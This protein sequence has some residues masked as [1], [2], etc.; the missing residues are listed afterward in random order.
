[1]AELERLKSYFESVQIPKGEFRIN[2]ATVSHNLE[3]SINTM[4]LRAGENAGNPT[5]KGSIVGLQEIEAVLK[6]TITQ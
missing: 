6:E 1:M 5:Y 2:A 3:K 4:L